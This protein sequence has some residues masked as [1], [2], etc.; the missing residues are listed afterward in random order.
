MVAWQV[1]GALEAIN[2]TALG[3]TG[4]FDV[5]EGVVITNERHKEALDRGMVSLRAA[6]GSLGRAP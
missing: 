2:E 6:Q 4:G 5:A 1:K 3:G